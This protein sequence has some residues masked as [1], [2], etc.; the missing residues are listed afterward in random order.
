MKNTRNNAL[1]IS[2]VITI[3]VP[4]TGIHIHKLAS[5]LFL[6]LIIVHTIA[7]RRKLGVKEYFLLTLIVI[8]FATG[9]FGMI[10]N[11]C[12]IILTLH[13]SISIDVVFFAAIHILLPT[14]NCIPRNNE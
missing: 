12:P 4:L 13:R 9:L 6:L 8:S 5:T 10:L 11:Q 3:M 2:F 1:L 14:S 7:C